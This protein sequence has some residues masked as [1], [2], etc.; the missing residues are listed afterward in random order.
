MIAKPTGNFPVGVVFI[1]MKIKTSY[2]TGDAMRRKL[3][4]DSPSP[5]EPG[6]LK[7]GYATHPLSPESFNL[8]Q[9]DWISG[10]PAHK[11]DNLIHAHAIDNFT[12][13][14]NDDQFNHGE[15]GSRKIEAG[16]ADPALQ[17]RVV[18]HRY[19]VGF[20][21]GDLLVQT[22]TWAGKI[23]AVLDVIIAKAQAD[24]ASVDVV[25]I[26]LQDFDETPNAWLVREKTRELLTMGIPVAVAA[27]NRGPEAWNTLADGNAFVVQSTDNGQLREESGPG[28]MRAEG[29]STSFSAVAVT[30]ILGKY[31]TLGLSIAEMRVLIEQDMTTHGGAYP[32]APGGAI[33]GEFPC[34]IRPIANPFPSLLAL[35]SPAEPAEASISL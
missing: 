1:P 17:G 7:H 13:D 22:D 21:E 23:A 29:G 28:N 2:V 15:T 12:P 19:N 24:P 31:K 27:G 9:V 16:G 32:C 18:V 33:F 3:P 30:P 35:P 25:N 34:E 26:S 4:P 20:P 11:P 10:Q 5:H 14:P 6:A 8:E